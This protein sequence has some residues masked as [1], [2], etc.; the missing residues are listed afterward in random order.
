MML[1]MCI[2]WNSYFFIV[3]DVWPNSDMNDEFQIFID[4]DAA[5]DAK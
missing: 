2:H 4:M 3:Y 5:I 1:N